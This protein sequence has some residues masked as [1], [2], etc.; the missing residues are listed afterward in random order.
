MECCISFNVCLS[1]SI[2]RSEFRMMANSLDRQ[3]APQSS[4][5]AADATVIVIIIIIIIVITIIIAI[6]IRAIIA[7]TTLP[8]SKKM[9]LPFPKGMS[10]F[11]LY[12]FF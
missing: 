6:A 8:L 4:E 11:S 5:A 1:P 7:D 10:F 12:L 2:S 3:T 9:Q